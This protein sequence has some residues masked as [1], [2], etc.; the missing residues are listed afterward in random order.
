[1]EC[2][3]ITAFGVLVVLLFFQFISAIPSPLPSRIV[4]TFAEYT[5]CEAGEGLSLIAACAI[6]AK[7]YG[8]R[9]VLEVS[10]CWGEVE[11][12]TQNEIIYALTRRIIPTRFEIAMVEE[13]ASFSALHMDHNSI[14]KRFLVVAQ[15]SDTDDVSLG[16]GSSIYKDD[17][18]PKSI[19]QWN[20]DMLNVW[21]TW[22]N[23]SSYGEGSLVAVLDS[24]IATS[25]IPAFSSGLDGSRILP[26]YDF[27]SDKSLS[28]DGD[29]RDDVSFDP[30]DADNLF[31]PGQENSW[32]GTKVASVLGANYSGFYG[33]AP[34]SYIL[35]VRVLGKCSTGF[36][37][38]VA[39]GIVW[40][41]GGVIHGLNATS[42]TYKHI[43][44]RVIVMAF[45][46]VGPCPSFM[47]TAVDLAVSRNITI[48][49]AAGNKPT[50]NA[51]EYF[52]ANCMGVVSVGSLTWKNEPASYTSRYPDIFMPGGD[53]EKGIPCLSADLNLG[54]RTCMGTSMAVPHAGGLA[55]LRDQGL[56]IALPGLLY[57]CTFREI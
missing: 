37:S 15:V 18:H 12:S 13:D 5:A 16:I 8:R 45:A 1:M 23:V 43:K 14:Y 4:V 51:S 41:A 49:A 46:G 35:P 19:Q 39:D 17:T 24:G 6:M 11:R 36:A 32:H 27:I 30:G 53:S 57:S 38:D 3:S 33:V 25:A 31:C 52:P 47:Q 7:C 40:A 34:W 20:L 10:N 21:D 55:A 48:F 42:T 29:G 56:S 28:M 54:I 50:L 2:R 22:D 26:G 9:L 44:N